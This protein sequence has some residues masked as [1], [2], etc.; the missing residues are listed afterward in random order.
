MLI[1][2]THVLRHQYTL[3]VMLV[4]ADLSIGNKHAI[5]RF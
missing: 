4:V 2:Y 3:Y 5:I 1:I